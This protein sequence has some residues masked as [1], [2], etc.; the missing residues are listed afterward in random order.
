MLWWW[1]TINFL[2][3]LFLFHCGDRTED[4][5]L[6]DER[7]QSHVVN[8][9]KSNSG[10]QHQGADMSLLSSV[11]ANSKP[12]N[13]QPIVFCHTV[14]VPQWKTC[15]M[16][17]LRRQKMGKQ[18]PPWPWFLFVALPSVRGAILDLT[19][20]EQDSEESQEPGKLCSPSHLFLHEDDFLI[21]CTLWLSFCYCYKS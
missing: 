21:S 4:G 17:L 2:L 20:A 1:P 7:R 18:L 6:G 9:R 15:L 11:S 12:L 3:L 19:A 14:T 10:D 5:G 8:P 16:Q 13:P